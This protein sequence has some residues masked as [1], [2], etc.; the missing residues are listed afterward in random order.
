MRG[1]GIFSVAI[2]TM[3]GV[4]GF[5]VLDHQVHGLTSIKIDQ[6]GAEPGERRCRLQDEGGR[7]V[8]GRLRDVHVYSVPIYERRRRGGVVAGE[9]GGRAISGC[10][11]DYIPGRLPYGL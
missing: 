11:N 2:L 10:V 5:L 7:V 1:D 3:A 4:V 8:D 9:L 6:P